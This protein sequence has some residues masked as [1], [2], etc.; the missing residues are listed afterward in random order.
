MKMPR[1]LYSTSD[2]RKYFDTDFNTIRNIWLKDNGYC[3]A[4]ADNGIR[5]NAKFVSKQSAG[6]GCESFIELKIYK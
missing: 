6:T 1:R 3:V 2:I 4:T 5:Y